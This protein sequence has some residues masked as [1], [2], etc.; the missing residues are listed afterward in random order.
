MV[1]KEF[2][3]SVEGYISNKEIALIDVDGCEG[4]EKKYAQLFNR[5]IEAVGNNEKEYG[6]EL[7]EAERLQRRTGALLD[8]NPQGIT[9]LAADK[10]RIHLNKE[11]ERIWR[12]TYDELM[13][14][15]LYDF[16][17]TITAGADFYASYETKK[18]EVSDME[19]K[20]PN[21]EVTYLRLFQTPIL[22][23][24]GEIDVN[25]YIYQD[26]TE[27]VEKMN[28]IKKLEEQSKA[29]VRE[30]PMPII[31]WNKDTTVREA[32][33][34][35]V[36]VSGFSEQEAKNLTN[37]DFRYISQAGKS[38]AETIETKKASHGE[39]TI[40][41][42]AGI[43]T[44][45]RYNI[46]L[47]DENGMVDSVLTVYNDITLLR[48]EINNSEKLQKRTEAFLKDNPQGITVLAGDKH[49]LD[50]NKEYERIWRGTYDELMAKKLY[51][52]DITVTGGDDFYASYETKRKA[53]SDLE[54]NWQNGEK[55]YL[56]LFQTPILDENGEIDVNYYIYQDLT[57]QTNELKE[58]QKLQKR[59]DTFLKDNPQAITVLAP[60]K[61]RLDLNKEYERAWRGSYNE[62]MAKK[63]YDF[64]I[65][66]TGDDF[67][68]SYETK[69]KAV[70][71][72][73]I[74]W[75]DHT[76]SYL[77]LFQ[78]P[79]LDDDGNIDVNYYIYQDRTPEVSQSL[80]MDSEVKKV[81]ADLEAI[82]QGRPEEMKL[83]VGEADQYTKE[84]RNQFLEITSSVG[85]VNESLAKL[86]TDIE[87]LV[88]AGEDGK[89]DFRADTNKY[90]GAY[91]DMIEG[92]NN[93]LV[94]AAIPINESLKI[95]DSFADADFTAR[96]SDDIKVK[97]DF[98]RL[99]EALNNIGINVAENL[100]KSAEV[101]RQVAINS[102]EV[103]KGTNE[104]SKAAEAVANTSQKAADLT[105]D[106]L[107]NIEDINRQ[108]AD[109]SA[110][111]EEIASTSQEVFNA[112]NGVVEIG[113]EA[114]GLGNDA[115]KKM[116]NVE[117]I[118]KESVNEINDLT[119]KVKE[120][121]NVVKLIND[122]TGQINLLALNAAIEAARAGE[123]GRGFAVVAGEVKNLA[124][125]A[126]A[127]TD[128]IES[129]VS[130]VQTSSEKTAGAINNANNEIVE[131][132]GS[133]TKALEAL[134][135]IIKNAG[136]VTTDIGEI[137]RAI[138]DQANIS[139]NVVRSVD[140]GTQKTKEVQR[141]AE[142]LAALA[143]EASAS[144]EEIGS[145]IH[146]VSELV[147]DLDTANSRFKY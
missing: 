126:R 14:K 71:D 8:F 43:K 124:A 37:R 123:H 144:V 127:A 110:S 56:R 19:I 128:S 70:S 30:N 136:Q 143:E 78:T 77:R 24:K 41:F 109:L 118:A 65:T 125:E 79:I 87:A 27:Q 67:Y 85:D 137:T 82:A 18:N 45:E 108:I 99:K 13:A 26:L 54:I 102:E 3:K 38:V 141:E 138:E 104:V 1:F 11:Y 91:I 83:E 58:V 42:P 111:N 28:A 66:V 44:V 142:E 36:K 115:N 84:I 7:R 93:L 60:D 74:R 145:A 73:E 53:V 98:L 116:G 23:N 32:N 97:G 103:G 117:K 20:W 107:I 119:E 34:A 49:R 51:D 2:E 40:E 62:L 134:N 46:P 21:G 113:K 133:V 22:N 122:I 75:P 15:K 112:A 68:A 147:K 90:Q 39:A 63:L 96:F 76:K 55:T 101:T 95:C 89:L 120:V 100:K 5:L 114:Q 9:V 10:H 121:S 57:E 146:E 17:I 105:K 47:L 35:F 12:G 31:L 25:Y 92:V 29:I 86:L 130:M 52:F 64:D 72:L 61:H 50:L 94:T 80:Y 81:A 48:E 33:K 16:D 132:V 129:V 140:S 6:K 131:G 59:A 4:E 88:K 139:N 106:L 69:R 135:T